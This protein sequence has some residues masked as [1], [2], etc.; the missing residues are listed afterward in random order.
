MLGGQLARDLALGFGKLAKY[1]PF[2]RG[3][4]TTLGTDEPA[5]NLAAG[6]AH[7]RSTRRFRALAADA[8]AL[9]D[10]G[11]KGDPVELWLRLLFETMPALIERPEVVGLRAELIP[12]AAAASVHAVRRLSALANARALS[13]RFVRESAARVR[14]LPTLLAW[15]LT[16]AGAGWRGATG[17]PEWL[18][19]QGREVEAIIVRDISARLMLDPE[20]I[21]QVGCLSS[22][23]SGVS[24]KVLEGARAAHDALRQ[25]GRDDPG[26]LARLVGQ[27]RERL[28]AVAEYLPEVPT[29]YLGALRGMQPE[30]TVSE[31]DD[32]EAPAKTGSAVA[33]TS[34][35]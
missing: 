6:G 21:R 14:D 12:D 26:Y 16:L 28:P 25:L 17:E 31:L 23:V 5:Y 1:D 19:P 27:V 30:L 20:D 32:T 7:P 33:P 10:P 8:A 35:S 13:E 18:A 9:F 4:R 11:G 34:I 24:P 2:L 22:G 15:S 3:D 29:P